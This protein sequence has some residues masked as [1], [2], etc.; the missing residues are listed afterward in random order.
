MI[1]KGAGFAV[2][3]PQF[4]ALGLMGFALLGLSLARFRA[5]VAAER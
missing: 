3:W 5:S 4:L 1:F 2:V